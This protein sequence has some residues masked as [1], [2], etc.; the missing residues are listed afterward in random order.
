M[1]ISEKADGAGP[2]VLFLVEGKLSGAGFA[3]LIKAAVNLADVSHPAPI[4]LDFLMGN[5]ASLEPFES[6]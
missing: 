3:V 2:H 4:Q 5:F 6:P 1:T